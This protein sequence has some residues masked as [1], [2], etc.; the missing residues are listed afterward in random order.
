MTEAEIH[1]ANPTAEAAEKA[2][3]E[4]L[5]SWHAAGRNAPG[6]ETDWIPGTKLD[7]AECLP[8]RQ[9]RGVDVAIGPDHP[10]P[11]ATASGKA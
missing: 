11:G 2:M 3:P 9:V 4:A 1:Y 10:F 7:W 6:A 8:F 5:H